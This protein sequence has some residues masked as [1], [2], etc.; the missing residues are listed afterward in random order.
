[1]YAV[2]CAR[3]IL[4]ISIY[5][6]LCGRGV[7]AAQRQDSRY[8]VCSDNIQW[9]AIK[10]RGRGGLDWAGKFPDLEQ[11]SQQANELLANE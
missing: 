11:M 9:A 7:G 2:C 10:G 1:M 6:G 5:S 4:P 3:P 8:A